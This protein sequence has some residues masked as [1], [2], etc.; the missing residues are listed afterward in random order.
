[1]CTEVIVKAFLRMY[2]III[3]PFI[4]DFSHIAHS[5]EEEA[6]RQFQLAKKEIAAWGFVVSEEKVVKPSRRNVILGYEIDTVAMTI[7]FDEAKWD[8]LRFLVED[9]LQPKV[10]ARHLAKVVGKMMALGYA[11]RVPIASFLPRTIAAIAATT[12]EG[13]WKSWRKE[14]VVTGQ[15]YEELLFI[16]HNIKNWNGQDLK[17]PM[18]IHF[19]S[20]TNPVAE[21]P[22]EPF[23]GD[24]SQEACAFFSIRNPHKFAIKF[25]D[26]DLAM[27]SSSK[28]E[29]ASIEM[30]VMEHADWFEP[31]S[32]IVYASDSTSVNRW[33]NVGSC[34]L[35]VAA[36]L[37]R[38]FLKCFE[39][40]VDLRVTWVPR[41]HALLED[42]DL[43]S[44]R[45][46]D[47]FTLRNRDWG[48]IRG[49]YG[50]EFTV[51]I[52]A[53]QFLHRAKKYYSKFPSRTSSGTD[54][55]YQQWSQEHAWVF[56]PRKLLGP[57]IRRIQ[58][59]V[60]L[61]GALVGLDNSEGLIRSILFPNNHAPEWV[62]QVYK[63]PIKVR[64]GFSEQL[65][66]AM[67]NSFSANWHDVVILFIDKS[68]TQNFLPARC[69]KKKGECRECGGND[70][71]TD[72]KHQY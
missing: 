69:F 52:F 34:K 50:V 12:S 17:K 29:L 35:D 71:V 33:V 9:A 72:V 66:D 37:Q 48:Y 36:T 16:V 63:F 47:E 58:V 49:Q 55:L 67:R 7:R 27:A 42:A 15:M 70:Y 61:R 18:H 11:S 14:M 54:G 22:F 2:K 60:D 53:S 44:R 65:S 25:F 3:N 28:R 6:L 19:F 23:I 41:S 21:K 39:L 56:P 64:M 51:D 1:M 45:D 5:D 43:L 40:R 32:T 26:E 20:S 13:D 8:E 4:D 59:E 10:Q 31:G 68:Y 38:I 46:T 62:W 30:L 57:C 24:A